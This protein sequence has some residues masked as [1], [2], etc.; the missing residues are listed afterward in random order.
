MRTIAFL[1]CSAICL[2]SWST[3]N[4]LSQSRP[5]ILSSGGNFPHVCEAPSAF[6][7]T[8]ELMVTLDSSVFSS[9]SVSLTS[10]AG[11]S[12]TVNATSP[13]VTIPVNG[14]SDGYV[15]T[16]DGGDYGTYDGVF[17][18]SGASTVTLTDQQVGAISPWFV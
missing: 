2:S 5:V 16:I 10:P 1:L 7:S 4:G 15:V 3:T 9:Y 18:R 13:T 12:V 6:C 11:D 8:N 17:S 14:D